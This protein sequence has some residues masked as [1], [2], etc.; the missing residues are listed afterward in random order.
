MHMGNL[1]CMIDTISRRFS[2]PPRK[3]SIYANIKSGVAPTCINFNYEDETEKKIKISFNTPEELNI[4]ELL[5]TII[6][7]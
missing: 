5:E 2:S 7:W 4:N 1:F 3:K 6:F